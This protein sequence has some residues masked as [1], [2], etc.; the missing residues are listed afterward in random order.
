LALCLYILSEQEG[1]HAYL[2]P[3]YEQ[4]LRHRLLLLEEDVQ[5]E[6]VRSIAMGIQRMRNVSTLNDADGSASQTTLNSLLH[7]SRG[8]EVFAAT[9]S[10]EEANETELQ[11]NDI[12][13]GQ[14][15]HRI[16]DPTRNPLVDPVTLV[17]FYFPD[18]QKL[19]G[20]A[21]I[22]P[23]NGQPIERIP[24]NLQRERLHVTEQTGELR[25]LL[26]EVWQ[27][28]EEE[29]EKVVPFLSEAKGSMRQSVV[30]SWSDESCWSKNSRE[31][32]TKDMFP[33]KDI[34]PPNVMLQ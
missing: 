18:D 28:I 12:L 4:Q 20:V 6:N 9:S 24:I 16:F 27:R 7:H 30:I 3:Y 26:A 13:Y 29:A 17:I 31:R 22:L 23:P 32:I 19:N 25:T 21:L 8:N 2:R 10:L 11:E 1:I 15:N 14:N 5:Q 33:F 34:L